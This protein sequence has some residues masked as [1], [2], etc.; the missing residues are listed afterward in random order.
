MRRGMVLGG[1]A[2]HLPPVKEI[3]NYVDDKLFDNRW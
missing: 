1:G 2:D 3:V